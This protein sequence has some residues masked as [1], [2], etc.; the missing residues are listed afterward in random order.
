MTEGYTGYC[1]E[2]HF[3][4]LIS[5][6]QDQ[7]VV[8]VEQPPASRLS[9]MAASPTGF[10]PYTTQRIFSLHSER[11][12][13]EIC[14]KTW[15][16]AARTLAVLNG[17]G[18]LKGLLSDLQHHREAL[19]DGHGDAAGHLRG[20]VPVVG[21]HGTAAP[22]AGAAGGLMA[23]HLIDHPGRMPASSSQVAKVWRKS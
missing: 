12:L 9:A 3:P 21:A 11:H 6:A 16:V 23:H 19:L 2:R 13:P 10:V 5:P 17:S 1:R 18:G 4:Q 14:Q 7:F 8:K 22:L 20:G 15:P